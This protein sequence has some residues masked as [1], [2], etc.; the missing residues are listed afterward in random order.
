MTTKSTNFLKIG[1]KENQEA[2]KPIQH[3]RNIYHN[4]HSVIPYHAPNKN[5]TP[6][7]EIPP[8][9]LAINDP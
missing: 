4:D 7:F 6:Y 3:P 5:L 1:E 9:A 2:L 8:Y